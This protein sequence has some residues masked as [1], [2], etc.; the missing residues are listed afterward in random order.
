MAA[1]EQQP[2]LWDSTLGAGLESRLKPGQKASR[3]YPR[4]VGVHGKG[5]FR[6]S[7]SLRPPHH[8]S[9]HSSVWGGRPREFVQEASR[10]T[11]TT[12]LSS[13]LCCKPGAH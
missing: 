10:E 1:R 11:E 7:L 12:G 6:D 8:P 9:S 3:G 5:L 4:L 2:E 13:Q